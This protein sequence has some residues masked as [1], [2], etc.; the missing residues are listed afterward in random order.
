M[1]R[2]YGLDALRGL[3]A[4]I[5]MTGHISDLP[6]STMFAGNY[7]LCVD[8]FLMLSGYVLTRTYEARMRQGL[9]CRAFMTKRYWRLFPLASLGAIMALMVIALEAGGSLRLADWGAF[10]AALLFLPY[11]EP[12]LFPV[13]GP[14]WSL[15]FE[16]CMNLLHVTVLHRLSV[17]NLAIFLV[18]VAV[19][20]ITLIQD[21]WFWPE[22]AHI[23]EFVPGTLRMIVAYT[24]GILLWRCAGERPVVV[25]RLPVLI[26]GFLAMVYFGALFSSG[27]VGLVSVFLICPILLLG[28]ASYQPAP[29]LAWW[30]G[31][32]GAVSYPI[33]ALH[34][35]LMRLTEWA[36]LSPPQ[37]LVLAL[38]TV[39]LVVSGVVV[40]NRRSTGQIEAAVAAI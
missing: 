10:A 21:G 32:L 13:N 3:A 36:G 4:I 34:A 2:L 18:L 26:G 37:I 24:I 7:G 33:Y 11:P 6:Q 22:P 16:L 19:L 29:R 12:W 27:K 15:F 35:P 40:W 20:Q 17:R 31:A 39:G 28:A 14:R 23:A 1:P 9:G 8:F 5:V 38:T 30:C 25:L